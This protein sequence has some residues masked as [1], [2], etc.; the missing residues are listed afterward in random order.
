MVTLLALAAALLYGSADFLGGTA[1]RKARLLSVLLVSSVSGAAVQL[2]AALVF[3]GPFRAAGIEWGLLAGTVGGIGLAFFYAGLAAGPMSVVSPVSAL[4]STV[5]PVG[6]A[7]AQGERPGAAVYAGALLCLAATVLVSS[8]AAPNKFGADGDR[9]AAAGAGTSWRVRARGV[10]YGV[11][12]GAAF[13]MFFLFI[14][15]G[16]ESGAFWPVAAARCAGLA[17]FVLAALALRTPP[18]T[19][20]AGWLAFAAAVGSGVIDASANLCYVLATRAGLF[21]LAVVL[22]SLYPGVTVL[23]ARVLLR[24][25]MRRMQQAG[26]ALAALGIALVSA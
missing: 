19:W 10:G 13:G 1:T 26:L 2:A 23:L 6:F 7:I 18:V 4:V 20:R 17:I 9:P 15:N 5:L 21:G 12:S 8:G 24:E 25:R 22:T 14:R 16:G 11:A 3:G